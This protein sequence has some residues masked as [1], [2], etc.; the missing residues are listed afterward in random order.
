MNTTSTQRSEG[1]DESQVRTA[2]PSSFASTPRAPPIAPRA[3]RTAPRKGRGAVRAHRLPMRF[4]PPREGGECTPDDAPRARARAR[5]IGYFEIHGGARGVMKSS[6]GRATV[7][8][9]AGCALLLAVLSLG[10]VERRALA[11]PAVDLLAAPRKALV[12]RLES[13]A[14]W[15]DSNRLPGERD[16]TFKRILLVDS[17]H[18]R[19]RGML[20]YKKV[21]KS[22]RWVQKDYKEPSDWNRGLLPDA[23]KRRIDAV[24][25]FRSEAKQSFDA[26]GVPPEDG[27]REEA[28]ELSI[29]LAPDDAGFRSERGDVEVEGA[30]VLAETIESRKRRVEF[31]KALAAM[32][33]APVKSIATAI[34]AGWNGAAATAH[35][36]TYS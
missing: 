14:T 7:G 1:P 5:A 30:W 8:A 34:A 4:E 32:Q 2:G 27:R 3:S 20:K 16:R 26:A 31:S 6:L 33:P 13:L 21:E 17:E 9:R 23:K 12:A 22:D 24:Q 18:A 19:S 35:F 25:L 28:V 29:D 10:A 11:A 15:C 36:E